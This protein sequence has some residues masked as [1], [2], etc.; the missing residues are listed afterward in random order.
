M[1]LNSLKFYKSQSLCKRAE[2]WRYSSAKD[3]T[4]L[5]NGTLSNQTLAKRLFFEDW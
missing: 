1:K 5:R 2:D 3:Y 4:G